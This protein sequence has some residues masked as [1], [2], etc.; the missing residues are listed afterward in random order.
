MKTN[1]QLT[2][3]NTE[4]K[5]IAYNL[6]WMARRYADGRCTY[7]PGMVND[8][9]RKLQAMGVELNVCGERTPWARDGMG[10]GFSGLSLEEYELGQPID[11]WNEAVKTE[12]MEALCL[13]LKAREEELAKE[14]ED[15]EKCKK[16]IAVVLGPDYPENRLYDALVDL[17][18]NYSFQKVFCEKAE[19]QVAV[20]GGL[21]YRVVKWEDTYPVDRIYPPFE[22]IRIA[23]EMRQI[24]E[25]ARIIIK[26]IQATAD[27]KTF[28]KDIQ[29]LL[30]DE[31]KAG[32]D[33]WM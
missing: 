11:K 26:D 32:C 8:A 13:R 6:H 17:I 10:P 1:E 27:A 33:G 15:I 20:L 9:V 22:I 30:P 3:E 28:V 18:G 19:S 2:A 14:K 5:Q 16:A 4:L 24:V 7:A 25:E 12:E 29:A 31:K 21:L 23:E